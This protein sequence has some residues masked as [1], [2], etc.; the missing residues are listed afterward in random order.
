[1]SYL[2]TFVEGIITFI[3][4]CMLPLLPVYLGFFAGGGPQSKRNGALRGA[5]GFILGFTIAF[6][7]MGAV[8]GGIGAALSQWSGLLEK[9]GGLLIILFGLNYLGILSIGWLN[10]VT[11][12]EVSTEKPGFL[13][14]LL[15]G[16]AFSI[17][18][19]PCVGAFL[20][21]A[22]LMASQQGSALQGVLLLLSYC[23]GLGIPFLLAAL[24]IDQLESTLRWIKSHYR[25]INLISGG[26]LVAMGI[27]MMT[28]LLAR[29]VALLA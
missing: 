13:A 25:I 11:R 26:L 4:P 27:L 5:L 16:L 24:L 8:A 12:R 21:S 9:L 1:M 22:L 29:W 7:A 10:R 2:L 23:A 19:S 28:G 3:S 14:S 18:W 15:F 6:T 20:G 17:G